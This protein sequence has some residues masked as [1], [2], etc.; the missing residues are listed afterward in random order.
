M[1]PERLSYG[2][3]IFLADVVQFVGALE[4]HVLSADHPDLIKVE[5][6]VTAFE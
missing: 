6:D 1:V 4:E 2:I 5:N 3:G